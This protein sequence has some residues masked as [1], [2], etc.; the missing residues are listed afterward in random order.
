M[1]IPAGKLAIYADLLDLGDDA[2]AEILAGQIVTSPAPLPRHSKTQGA[3]RRYV[4]GPFDDD[5][6]RGGPGGRWI[7]VEVDIQLGVHDVVRPDLAGWRRVRLPRPGSA[8]PIT[9]VPD[10]TCEITSPSTAARDRAAK[11]SLYAQYGVTHYWIID[12]DERTL[13]ALELQEGRWVGVGAWDETATARIAP[14][15]E[16]ELEV[17]RLFLPRE[18][19]G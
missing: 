7:F 18:A 19:D 11:R 3:L 16:V 14:F 5:D 13:E 2:R 1:S 4:G 12:P 8:R 17:G 6:G 10:W 9:I 15:S